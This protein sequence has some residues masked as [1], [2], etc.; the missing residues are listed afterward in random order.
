MENSTHGASITLKKA[1]LTELKQN[2]YD[3]YEPEEATH[4]AL[5]NIGNRIR[6]GETNLFDP[7]HE[8]DHTILFFAFDPTDNPWTF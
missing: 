7:N 1:L 5:L 4:Q 2:K 8:E 6:N 3:P